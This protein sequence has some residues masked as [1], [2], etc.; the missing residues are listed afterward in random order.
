[1][2]SLTTEEKLYYR[3]ANNRN[4]VAVCDESECGHLIQAGELYEVLKTKRRADNLQF[5]APVETKVRCKLCSDLKNGRA[6]QMEDGEIIHKKAKNA[7]QE[8]PDGE[9]GIHPGVRRNV[10]R[11]LKRGVENLTTD[12]LIAT[13]H[14]KRKYAA[15]KPSVFRKTLQGMRVNQEIKKKAGAWVLRAKKRRGVKVVK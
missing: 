2:P 13:V 10:L 1:M 5:L 14:R 9:T 15:L 6:K 11:I 8:T 7:M 4:Y 3:T 12:K